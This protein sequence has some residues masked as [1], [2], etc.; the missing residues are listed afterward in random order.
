MMEFEFD[1]A[2]SRSNQLKHGLDFIE[3][4]NL[5]LDDNRLEIPAR[6]TDEVRFVLLA[7]LQNKVWAAVITHRN[8]TIRI[9]SV[10]RARR[11]EIELY[12]GRGI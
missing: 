6:V 4:Q 8:E 1:E 12:E 2:K 7:R 5:W 9:I 3:A 11:R 10:R